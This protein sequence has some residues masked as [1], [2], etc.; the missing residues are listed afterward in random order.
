MNEIS[1]YR[2]HTVLLKVLAISALLRRCIRAVRTV[3]KFTLKI[4]RKVVNIIF[5][6]GILV[7]CSLVWR[8]LAKK[9]EPNWKPS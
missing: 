1:T 3:N 2:Q 6:S 9:D 5:E 8:R 7:L 4:Y